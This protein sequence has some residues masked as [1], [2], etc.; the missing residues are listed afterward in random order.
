MANGKFANVKM[1]KCANYLNAAVP[2]IV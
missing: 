2:H 1:C